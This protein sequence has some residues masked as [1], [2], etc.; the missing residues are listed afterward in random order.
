MVALLQ[1]DQ[2]DRFR[3]DAVG[4]WLYERKVVAAC[5]FLGYGSRGCIYSWCMWNGILP[6]SLLPLKNVTFRIIS[7]RGGNCF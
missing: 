2:A 6:L 1:L 3:V 7:E 4:T 5:T